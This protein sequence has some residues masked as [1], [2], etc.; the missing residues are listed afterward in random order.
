[1]TIKNTTQGHCYLTMG[2]EE[3]K[4]AIKEYVMKHNNIS[5]DEYKE[6]NI[7]MGFEEEKVFT[8]L[9]FKNKTL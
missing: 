1:M 7:G 6:A 4:N 3:V 9:L 2:I 5:E 8:E